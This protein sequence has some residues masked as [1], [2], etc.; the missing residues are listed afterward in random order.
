MEQQQWK[1]YGT[2]AVDNSE[3]EPHNGNWCGKKQPWSSNFIQV[4][5][6][7]ENETYELKFWHRLQD[8]IN[9]TAKIREMDAAGEVQGAWIDM[10]VVI[11]LLKLEK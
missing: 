4:I 8:G 5:D 1:S 7:T 11:P 3:I 6:V 10:E 2:V 9:T